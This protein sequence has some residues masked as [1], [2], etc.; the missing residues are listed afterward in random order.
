MVNACVQTRKTLR[1]PHDSRNKFT[2]THRRKSSGNDNERPASWLQSEPLSVVR[3]VGSPIHGNN[4]VD[5][6]FNILNGEFDFERRA[7]Q[8]VSKHR[9]A[10]SLSKTHYRLKWN[11]ISWNCR[12]MIRYL[13]TG[14]VRELCECNN[15]EHWQNGFYRIASQVAPHTPSAKEC[16][17]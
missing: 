2:Q 7:Y 8:Q 1:S 6:E 3:A 9:S 15:D 12:D 13:R 11:I 5:G 14:V 4:S 16:F 10:E 17:N